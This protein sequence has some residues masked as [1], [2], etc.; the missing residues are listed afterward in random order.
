ML[1]K[2]LILILVIIFLNNCGFK[3][4]DYSQLNNFRIV[5]VTT[6]GEISINYKLKNSIKVISNNKSDELIA[7]KLFSESKNTIKEKND[8]NEITKY[9]LEIITE[10]NYEF[11]NSG[12]KGTFTLSVYNDYSVADKYSQTLKNEKNLLEKLT[13]EMSSKINRRLSQNLNDF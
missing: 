10:V 13:N 4:L 3:V 9:K 12:K 8:K 6:S 1:K 11:L 2:K 7:L 5:E